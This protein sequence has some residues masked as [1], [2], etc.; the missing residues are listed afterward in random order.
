MSAV[1][2]TPRYALKMPHP[3]PYPLAASV[4]KHLNPSGD[5][6]SKKSPFQF[7]VGAVPHV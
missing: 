7:V 4:R 6:A 2:A 3:M 1:C 5:D